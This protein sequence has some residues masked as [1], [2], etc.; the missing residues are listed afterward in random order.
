MKEHI[1][2][3]WDW[4]KQHKKEL[5]ITGVSAIGGFILYK[6]FDNINMQNW[7]PP[8]LNISDNGID[9]N[10]VRRHDGAIEV[11]IYEE[12]PLAVMGEF[13]K[14]LVS[15]IPDLTNKSETVY[16]EMAIPN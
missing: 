5:A 3:G 6:K 14:Y 1:K 13:G 9:G 7:K 10:L 2:N 8:K 4:I 16:L 15:N 12:I 11:F